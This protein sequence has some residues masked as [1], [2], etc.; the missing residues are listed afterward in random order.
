MNRKY[1]CMLGLV[2]VVWGCGPMRQ[3]TKV[4]DATFP[5][6]PV[7]IDDIVILDVMALPAATTVHLDG[8]RVMNRYDLTPNRAFTCRIDEGAQAVLGAELFD[9]SNRSIAKIAVTG[10]KT[11]VQT[12]GRYFLE[13]IS[14]D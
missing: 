1:F 14:K 9:A 6:Q 3:I 5:E 2:A 4:Y 11:A 10:E 12:P 7:S 8:H 13:I